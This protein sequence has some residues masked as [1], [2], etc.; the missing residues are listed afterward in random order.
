MLE[1]APAAQSSSNSSLSSGERQRSLQEAHDGEA[2]VIIGLHLGENNLTGE[3]PPVVF[4]ALPEL[5][6]IE[7]QGN[8]LYGHIPNTNFAGFIHFNFTE[9]R[10]EYPPP[11]GLQGE[12]LRGRAMCPGFPPESCTAFGPEF[13]LRLDVPSACVRC[14]DTTASLVSTIAMFV[15]FVCGLIIYLI[16]VNRN[17][18]LTSAGVSTISI[19]VGHVQ[20]V[21]I[22]SQ[23]RLSW[24]ESTVVVN[25]L[26][27]A[28]GLNLEGARP[29]CLFRHTESDLPLFHIFSISK[30]SLGFAIMGALALVR[31][32]LRA[33]W[34]CK[35]ILGCNMLGLS[36]EAKRKRL[37]TLE[38]LETVIFSL[39]LTVSWRPAVELIRAAGAGSSETFTTLARI[40][41][42][43][44]I[45]LFV[46]Q[47]SLIAKYALYAFGIASLTHQARME[48]KAAKA[49]GA[50]STPMG[51]STPKHPKRIRLSVALHHA[52]DDEQER[53]T[54]RIRNR[55]GGWVAAYLTK[56]HVDTAR[57]QRRTSFLCSRY[58]AHAPYWQ[59][60]IWVRQLALFMVTILPYVG[61]QEYDDA[62]EVGA[63][64]APGAGP[65]AISSAQ[66]A[67]TL[68]IL[69]G[70]C[71]LNCRIQPYA[72]TFQNH[73]EEWLLVS[74]A[75]V[76]SCAFIY[77]LVPPGNTSVVVGIILT[78]ILVASIIISAIYA[79]YRY[80]SEIRKSV[81][82]RVAQA[83]AAAKAGRERMTRA[84]S[85][86]TSVVGMRSSIVVGG[87]RSSVAT[88]GQRSSMGV[89][90]R[91]CDDVAT[92]PAPSPRDYRKSQWRR[93]QARRSTL[94]SI[95]EGSMVASNASI[96]ASLSEVS[97]HC[98]AVEVSDLGARRP[99]P[100]QKPNSEVALRT[101]GIKQPSPPPKPDSTVELSDYVRFSG[102]EQPAPPPKP[103]STVE[104]SHYVRF[105]GVEQP[106]PPPLLESVKR[107]ENDGSGTTGS[108]IEPKA[109]KRRWWW[110]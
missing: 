105:S 100:P 65:D 38:K 101:D 20:T 21:Y 3:L 77:T 28:N 70:F 109:R 60:T 104:L 61:Q 30:L 32:V 19:I 23:L 15:L 94:V 56:R 37:D 83:K 80:R 71:L 12:C 107:P 52:G 8:R 110:R 9:N 74:S 59:F 73:L 89:D 50:P 22:V 63:D 14:R 49:A 69:V 86:A 96:Q 42:I 2:T 4:E 78:T 11:M 95:E 87:Q 55:L 62:S 17:K 81:E 72:F 97:A 54:S 48:K 106:A 90:R 35:K 75:A 46:F 85:R 67:A 10:F 40:G 51:D 53:T 43:L 103:D 93:S 29:E 27:V 33:I 108:V 76:V 68:T 7:V 26:L 18:Q 66:V 98:V 24:P 36:S 102:V 57:L 25:S 99:K 41:Y 64:L 13:E 79:I 82:Q 39:Q 16:F 84:M 88:G 45:V 92:P 91:S 44:A 34:Q 31:A 5:E 6:V 58:A 47:A 1:C